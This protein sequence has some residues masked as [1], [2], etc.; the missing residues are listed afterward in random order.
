MC[1][2][3]NRNEG[4]KSMLNVI[5]GILVVAGV[6]L[7]L[8]Q[9]RA[10][11]KTKILD[12]YGKL[13]TKTSDPWQKLRTQLPF[14]IDGVKG[15]FLGP[16][17]MIILRWPLS[18]FASFVTMGIFYLIAVAFP[19]PTFANVWPFYVVLSFLLTGLIG[20]PDKPLSVPNN[21]V[22]PL[23]F[24]GKLTRIYLTEGDYN[25]WM[26]KL[27]FNRSM[28]ALRD[29]TTREKDSKKDEHGVLIENTRQ[30]DGFFKITR[31]PFRLWQSAKE[32]GK[33]LITAVTKGGSTMQSELLV[34]L[35]SFDPY[36]ALRNDDAGLEIAERARSAL[37]TGFSFF[38]SIDNAVMKDVVARL[39]EGHTIVFSP[40]TKQVD[41]LPAGS[42]ARDTGGEPLFKIV[43]QQP[44]DENFEAAIERTINEFKTHL[45][46]HLT[47]AMREAVIGRKTRKKDAN[48]VLAWDYIVETRSIQE[49][50]T[51]ILE[52]NGFRLVSASIGEVLIDKSL[53]AAAVNAEQQSLEG[54]VQ[55]KSARATALAMNETKPSPEELSDPLRADRLALAAAGDP[56]AKNIK[57][58][59]VSSSGNPFA[60]A[61]A[62]M[63][64]QS[65]ET[66]Q[67]EKTE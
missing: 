24:F 35:E 40:L 36:L 62:L 51:E 61:A 4:I 42:V 41:D 64:P 65:P 7:L 10:T 56:G 58:N 57:F 45:D 17:W 13:V 30:E 46:G 55:V 21:T 34:T 47:P 44:G 59:R 67:V 16:I 19:G 22:A 49:A 31:I 18:L 43:E 29:F 28:I 33:I 11:I 23:T 52:K 38:T 1:R 48:G 6:A 3:D 14:R 27:F 32:V 37:R 66:P 20:W 9:Y 25:W 8:W 15:I 5:A 2:F 53:S 54:S 63:L 50:L 12:D 39:V 26:R 60:E